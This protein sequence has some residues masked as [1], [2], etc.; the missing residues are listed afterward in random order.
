PWITPPSVAANSHLAPGNQWYAPTLG[1][2]STLAPRTIGARPVRDALAVLDALTPDVYLTFVRDFYKAGLARF[3]D[4]SQYADINTVLRGLAEAMRPASYLEVG[5]RR[6]R[7]AAMVASRVPGC[8]IVAADMFIANYGN[9]DN[10][11]PDL[12]RSEL[13]RVGYD[14]PI[15]FLIGDSAK[16]LPAFFRAHPDDY[17]DLITIDGDHTPAG[18]RRD[19]RAAMPRVKLGGALVFDDITNPAYPWLRGVWERTVVAD[20]RFST[21]TYADIGFG[22]GFAIRKG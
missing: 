21:F 19:L 9:M 15:D 10:P 13:R 3:G 2:A 22:I 16:T 14:G 8:R 7:S 12:V 6:G 5:V 11:G 4:D 20:P 17:F 1:G 18:A